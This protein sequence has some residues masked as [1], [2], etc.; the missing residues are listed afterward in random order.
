MTRNNHKPC[1]RMLFSTA[2]ITFFIVPN[3]ANAQLVDAGDLVSA[4]DSSGNPG[5][6]AI[7]NPN[8]N[9]ANVDVLAPT[10]I[11]EWTDF[12][13]PVNTTL[14]VTNGSAAATASLLN[15]VIGAS[16]SD[17]GGTINASDVN[18][19]IINQNGILFG[20]DTVI[21][22]ESFVSSTLDVANQDFYDF[23]EGTDLLGN[24]SNTVNFN[25]ASPSS[26]SSA[27]GATITTD[28]TLLFASQALDLTGTFDAGGQTA[29]VA[30]SDV[31][32]QFQS[33]S[34][35][36]YTIASGTT[37]ASQNI[38]GSATGRGV[39]FQFV[40]AAGVVGALL[41][42]DANIMAT[43]ATPT[44]NGILLQSSGLGANQPSVVMN[45]TIS[46]PGIFSATI[47]GDFTANQSI[48]G[49][50]V[51]LVSASNITAGSI[52]SNGAIQATST[53]GGDID[54]GMLDTARTIRIDTAGAVTTGGITSGGALRIGTNA[55]IGPVA[56]AAINGDI[57]AASVSVETVGALNAQ[58][59]EST[60]SVID[61]QSP[62]G[63]DISVG[64]LDSASRII[65]NSTGLINVSTLSATGNIRAT[66]LT[67]TEA[68]DVESIGGGRL[69]LGNI[70][71]ARTINLDTTG[72]VR[73][74]AATAGGAL[75]VGTDGTIGR[76][77]SV[78]FA[79][80]ISSASTT[81]DTNG[82]VRARN[83][84]STVSS[85]DIESE[86][87]GAFQLG[88][89]DAATTINLDSTGTINTS[90][91]TA[92]GAIRTSSLSSAGNLNVESIG[93]GTLDLGTLNAAAVIN[94]DTS[95]IVRTGNVTAG[96]ALRVGT[97]T[98]IGRV[99]SADFTGNL[100][101]ASVNIDALGDVTAQSI[102]SRVSSIDI[103]STGGGSLVLGDLDSN[104]TIDLDTSSDVTGG[105]VTA[106]GALRVGTDAAIGPV[107]SANFTGPVNAASVTIRTSDMGDAEAI[108]SA[109]HPKILD[110]NT[111]TRD[112]I[113][114][115]DKDSSDIFN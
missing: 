19:W 95:G 65:L 42:V 4:I 43:T 26:I 35:L 110:T 29:F 106:V 93:G 50:A 87:S 109:D 2:L 90:N 71:A 40:T 21:N 54:L 6:I 53:N 99:A 49:S 94:L 79:G 104:T 98:G 61:L 38:A 96:G 7:T 83:I 51:S 103:D 39:D 92:A 36:S 72:A 111:M 107:A 48:S 57:S 66:S 32:V 5:Q 8:A 17:L 1:I 91:L 101:A 84:T 31:S 34:P 47:G 41:Q 12:N 14:N 115:T 62:N 82:T 75:R 55:G 64:T 76:T 33:G 24:G 102:E 25:G 70:T 9:T 112:D 80:N 74:G 85:I 88:T 52:T 60:V 77:S 114:T 67:S 113:E 59:I 68:L 81:I 13:V 20:S 73:V 37:V 86:N 45:G 27:N 100:S 105:M 22:A 23:Y 15:R 108:E 3:T 69:D 58:N 89:L 97:D 44:D 18:L 30:A 11:A 46:N 78:D 56:S 63:G 28:G 16:S 10:V